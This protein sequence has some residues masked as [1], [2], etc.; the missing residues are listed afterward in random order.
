M[1]RTGGDAMALQLDM[2]DTCAIEATLTVVIGRYGRLD[3]LHSHPCLQ[4]K[5]TGQ[6][7]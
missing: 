1:T 6:V 7:R 5:G 2:T 4:V 3:V